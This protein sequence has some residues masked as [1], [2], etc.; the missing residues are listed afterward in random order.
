MWPNRCDIDFVTGAREA[1][2]AHVTLNNN[3]CRKYF[4]CRNSSC[5]KLIIIVM[6][7]VLSGH[8]MDSFCIDSS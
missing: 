8:C 7:N 1:F 5:T 3:Y 4:V 2:P 6:D